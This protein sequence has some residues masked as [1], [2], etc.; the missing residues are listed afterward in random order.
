MAQSKEVGGEAWVATETIP[1]KD[2]M[3][4]LLHRGFKTAVL[5]MLMKMMGE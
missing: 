5:K 3:A 4:Y 2:L 1:E